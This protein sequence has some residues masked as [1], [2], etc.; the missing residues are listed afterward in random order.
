MGVRRE[1]NPLAAHANCGGASGQMS[2]YVT[3]IQEFQNTNQ[4]KES[5]LRF[6]SSSYLSEKSEPQHSCAVIQ[7]FSLKFNKLKN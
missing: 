1:H 3:F 5:T 7:V 6:V 2:D 4:I